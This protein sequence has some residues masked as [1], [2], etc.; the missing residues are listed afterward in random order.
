MVLAVVGLI[1]TG[2]GAVLQGFWN[3]RLEREKFEFSLIAKALT[4]PTKDEAAQNLKFLVEAGLINQFNSEKIAKLAANPKTLPSFLGVP[5]F[6]PVRQ[7]KTILSRIGTYQG[8]IDD[9]AN[10]AY[11]KAIVDF[12]T[13]QNLTPDGMIGAQTYDRMKSEYTKAT[14]TWPPTESP[15]PKP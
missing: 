7:G 13:A 1:G 11:F 9:E 12:Q 2:T 14:G 5:G 8:A 3:T 6:V 4:A 10:E 15:K